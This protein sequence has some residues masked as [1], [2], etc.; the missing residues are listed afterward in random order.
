MSTFTRGMQVFL[1]DEL[2]PVASEA[3]KFVVF[4]LLMGALL[5]AVL[6]SLWGFWLFSNPVH[7]PWWLIWVSRG[8]AMV[9]FLLIGTKLYRHI[10]L[11][12]ASVAS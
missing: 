8:S 4:V 5:L 2:W 9:L 12:L 3:G 10:L 11:R 6:G 7:T 1:R